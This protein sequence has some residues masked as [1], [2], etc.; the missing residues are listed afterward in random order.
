MEEYQ[1]RQCR[2]VYRVDGFMKTMA[3][4]G[5]GSSPPARRIAVH[6]SRLERLAQDQFDARLGLPSDG[7]MVRRLAAAMREHRMIQIAR[8]GKKVLKFAPGAERALTVPDKHSSPVKI[9]AAAERMLKL[10]RPCARLFVEHGQAKDFAVGLRDAVRE[11]RQLIRKEDTALRRHAVATAALA[12]EIR[13]ARVEVDILDGMLRPYT[14][15][16]R[17]LKH[18]WERAKRLGARKGRPK[19]QRRV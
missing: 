10:V 13:Q 7:L 2:S 19:Q 15:R 11:I 9:C 17:V 14:S 3:P 4:D 1:Q 5:L 6:V 12:V 8:V 18:M 16:D